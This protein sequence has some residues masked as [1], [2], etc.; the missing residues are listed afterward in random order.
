MKLHEI[1]EMAR[2]V[3]FDHP[4]FPD[5]GVAANIANY[6]AVGQVIPIEG[7]KFNI[8][9][10][11]HDY[12]LQRVSDREVLGW[13]ILDPKTTLG[14]RSVYPIVNI[15]IL[16]KYRKTGAAMMLVHA[17]RQIVNAPLCVDGPILNGGQ[18]MLLSLAKRSSVVRIST[19]D[20]RTGEK[21]PYDPTDLPEDNS[22]AVLIEKT[23]DQL[24][25]R[26]RHPG[27]Q[28][29]LICSYFEDLHKELL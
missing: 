3:P 7:G 24:A 17:V 10:R 5:D 28:I 1:I 26:L 29:K 27:G 22:R 2:I 18:S 14:K 25:I 15:Q 11:I 8:L 20:K 19:F 12:A 6:K 21:K 9:K 13:I 16:P 4:E 23:Y